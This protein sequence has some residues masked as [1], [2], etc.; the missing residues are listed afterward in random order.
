MANFREN[1]EVSSYSNA[2]KDQVQPDNSLASGFRTSKKA[3]DQG[4]KSVGKE[5]RSFF[6]FI[7]SASDG[8]TE[9]IKSKDIYGQPVSLNY[10]GE[11]TYKTLPGGCISILVLF[12]L[13][14]Y[15]LLKFKYMM[16]KEEWQLI[17]Q[18]VVAEEIDL[19]TIHDLS[20]PR[21]TNIS[22]ALQFRMKKDKQTLAGKQLALEN[23]QWDLFN[24]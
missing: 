24:K 22:L 18:T 16:F 10:Q 14:C 21:Y 6:G 8:V 20:D 23:R 3:L 7:K 12:V 11:D 17:Q 9:Y 19:L 1:S 4:D 15:S 2:F 5:R 13:L